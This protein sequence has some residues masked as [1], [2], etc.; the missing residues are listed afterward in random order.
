[1]ELDA[2]TKQGKSN[3]ALIFSP[4]LDSVEMSGNWYKIAYYNLL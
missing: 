2:Y 4:F 1:M 3:N